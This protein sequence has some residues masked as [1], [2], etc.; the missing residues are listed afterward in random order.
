MPIDSSD[1]LPPSSTTAMVDTHYIE[2]NTIMCDTHTCRDYTKNLRDS[3][4]HTQRIWVTVKCTLYYA[5][6]CNTCK[7]L[8]SAHTQCHTHRLYTQ[9]HTCTYAYTHAR[10]HAHTHTDLIRNTSSAVDT[11][12]Y[13]SGHSSRYV[14]VPF[15]FDRGKE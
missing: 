1:L 15:S 4:E 3:S 6:P 13:S 7:H 12:N 2:Q 10:T 11:V 9:A 5:K 14:S 8:V